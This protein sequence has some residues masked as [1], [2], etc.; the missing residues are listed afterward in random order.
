MTAILTLKNKLKLYHYTNYVKWFTSVTR[1]DYS[2]VRTP[3]NRIIM[4][5]TNSIKE[6]KHVRYTNDRKK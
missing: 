5:V 3:I 6:R 1:Q 4:F 2:H